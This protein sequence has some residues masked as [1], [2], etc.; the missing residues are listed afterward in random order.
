MAVSIPAEYDMS[1]TTVVEG[2]NIRRVICLE[3]AH[4]DAKSTIILNSIM[5]SRFGEVEWS[6]FPS[7]RE[8][9]AKKSTPDKK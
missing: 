2:Y 9:A 3:G 7:R 1:R 4:L 6:W 8:R 5:V